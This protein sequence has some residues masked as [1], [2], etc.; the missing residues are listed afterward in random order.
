MDDIQVKYSRSKLHTC[1]HPHS[2]CNTFLSNQSGVSAE[3][4]ALFSDQC[5]GIT[6]RLAFSSASVL[7]LVENG[8]SSTN[9][10]AIPVK[11]KWRGSNRNSRT[12][13]ASSHSIDKSRMH[14]KAFSN[15]LPFD[16]TEV[17]WTYTYRFY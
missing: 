9:T 4:S 6:G 2:G 8:N 1:T 3:Y 11:M 7:V 10:T 17:N 16:D 15:L 13:E 5:C 12:L 14:E